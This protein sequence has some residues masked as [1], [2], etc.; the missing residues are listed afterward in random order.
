M[1]QLVRADV[2]ISYA[3]A[4]DGPPVLF[5]QGIGVVGDGWQP[6][7][8]ALSERWQTLTFDNRGIGKS[9]PCTGPITVESMAG[10]AQELLDAAGWESAH[11]VGHS[12]G[13]A[14]AL[15]LALNVP[16]RVR[17]L[18]LL[19]T[20]ARGSDGARLTPR[21]L[22]MS[23]RTR[24]GTRRMRRR[25][26]MEM[27]WPVKDLRDHDIDALAI[28][29]GTLVGRDLADNPPILLKQLRAL[30]RHDLYRRLGELRGTSAL[31][32]SGE[33]DAIARPDSGRALA[34]AIPWAQFELMRGASHGLTIQHA[35][36]IND[37][38]ERFWS[39]R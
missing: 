15:Q 5:I 16:S 33:H 10:D 23:L 7:V 8:S 29:V 9:V 21:I 11:V 12:M 34:A 27:L 13:G 36:A 26:L 4:G 22:W 18:A 25:A 14:I 31:I 30:G 24:L 3:L 32:V 6:Q 2:A 19:C 28:Q 20:F 39:G 38:L 1:S 35:A 37:R 17:S